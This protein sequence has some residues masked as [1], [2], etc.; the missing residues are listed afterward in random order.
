LTNASIPPC[1]DAD[2]A[3]FQGLVEAVVPPQAEANKVMI[4]MTRPS[5]LIRCQ[6]I[7]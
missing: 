7:R 4:P 6:F 1:A 2:A 5:R 3:V